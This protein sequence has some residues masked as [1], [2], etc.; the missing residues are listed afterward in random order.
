MFGWGT[1]I[2]ACQQTFCFTG[3]LKTSREPH[4][5]HELL[6]RLLLVAHRVLHGSEM[7]AGHRILGNQCDGLLKSRERLS[8]PCFFK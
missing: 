5:L 8:V 4:R 7:I 3:F 2:E 6:L 1:P